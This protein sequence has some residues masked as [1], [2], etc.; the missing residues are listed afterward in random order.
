[1]LDIPWLLILCLFGGPVV[2]FLGGILIF[3]LFTRD[4]L[5]KED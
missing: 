5:D 3:A 4:H 1:M 2:G